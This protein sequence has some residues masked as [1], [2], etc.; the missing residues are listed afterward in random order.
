MLLKVLS[1][2]AAGIRLLLSSQCRF[3][4]SVLGSLIH[5]QDGRSFRV[6]RRVEIAGNT[7][8]EATFVIRFQ[9]ARM[10][11]RANIYFSYLPMIVMLGFPGFRSKYWCV[12]DETGVCQGVYEW[13]RVEDVLSYSS[14]F[15]VNF[16]RR[17]STPGSISFN[18]F[19]HR[20]TTHSE[21]Y[22]LEA[23]A[24]GA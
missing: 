19:D 14:S 4:Q 10:S 23:K 24:G 8:P 17:R 13:Q 2:F 6:F 21:I 16:M 1:Y 3:D 18:I 5:M 11:V 22:A 15:A 9:P 20:T 12:D 7:Q